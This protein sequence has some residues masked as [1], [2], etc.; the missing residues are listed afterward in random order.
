VRKVFATL[1]P[2]KPFSDNW[3]I[4]AICYQLERIRTGKRS[5]LIINMPPRSLKSLVCSIAFPAFVLGHDPRK[6]II[7]ISYSAD[8]AVKLSNDFRSIVTSGWYRE[9]FPRTRISKTKNT[10]FEIATTEHGFRLATSVGGTLT[11]RGG[12]MVII[13]DPL[14]PQDAKSD[15]KRGEVNG[16]FYNTV[17]SRLDDKQRGAI[18]VVMQRLHCDDLTGTLVERSDEWTALN[19]PAIAQQDAKIPIGEHQYHARNAGDVLHPEWESIVT[20]RKIQAQLGSDNF[21]A[22]YQQNPAPVGGNMIR[23]EWVQRYDGMLSHTPS[24]VVLQS[25]DTASKAGEQNA[26]TVCTTWYLVDRKYYLVDVMRGQFDYPLLKKLAIEHARKHKPTKILVE[27]SGVGTALI[28]EL[29]SAGFSPVGV[30]VKQDKKTRMAVQSAKF[31]SGRVYFPRAAPWLQEVEAEL[32]AFPA[33]RHDDQVDS[34]SQALAEE[35]PGGLGPGMS[36]EGYR[37]LADR[38]AFDELLRRAGR[39]W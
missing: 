22:Q 24:T 39:P 20:L 34:I 19:L 9:L 1:N 35:A 36:D 15:S 27:D 2:G 13:D 25:Y 32:F 38:L 11:G 14:K 23:R 37:K 6:R 30:Q 17:L 7:A 31:E 28:S 18:I 33:S 29:K 12:D 21:A 16:W 26:Y 3:H 5:R 4:E 10:E 8:L